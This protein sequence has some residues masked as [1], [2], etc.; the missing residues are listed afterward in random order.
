VL[1][2]ASCT[3]HTSLLMVMC[4]LEESPGDFF[5]G[6][7]TFVTMVPEYQLELTFLNERYTEQFE[8][9]S[10]SDVST[11]ILKILTPVDFLKF[12]TRDFKENE[13]NLV[14][15]VKRRNKDNTNYYYLEWAGEISGSAASGKFPLHFQP[16]E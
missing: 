2:L 16:A 6:F 4:T 14:F 5:R 10:H 15:E 13:K 3:T 8:V 9:N 11:I 12:L 7:T 1:L